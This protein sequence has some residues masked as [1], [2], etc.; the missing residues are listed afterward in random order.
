[1]K[2]QFQHFAGIL[3]QREV[4]KR[5]LTE[6]WITSLLLTLYLRRNPKIGLFFL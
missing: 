2:Q 4:V 1:M 3:H 5:S 6:N